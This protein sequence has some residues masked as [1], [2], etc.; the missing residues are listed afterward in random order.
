MED[1][2]IAA[3]YVRVSTDDQIE[4]SP[5][6]QL[7]VIRDHAQREGYIVPEDLIF[8]DDAI[9]GKHAEKRPQFMLLIAKA[10]EPDPGFDRIYVWEFSRF[11]RN[12]EESIVYKNLLRKR[13]ITV[14]SIKEPLADSPF[15]SLIERIIEWM[16]EYYLINLATEVKRGLN[17]KASR[18]EPIGSAPFG[19]S[20]SHSLKAYT[21]NETEAETVRLIFHQYAA[22]RSLSGLTHDLNENGFRTRAGNTFD[23]R[24]VK[25]ILSNPA[26]IGNLRWSPDGHSNYSRTGED[27]SRLKIFEGKHEPII[28]QETFQAVQKRISENA[29]PKGTYKR[30]EDYMLRGLIKC[31][32][33]GATLSRTHHNPKKGTPGLQCSKYAAGKCLVSHA[34]T[35]PS[36]EAAI[37]SYLENAVSSGEY[38]FQ[39]PPPEDKIAANKS[40]TKLIESENRR[41]ERARSAFLDGTFSADEYRSAKESAE[42]NITKLNKAKD[43][44]EKEIQDRKTTPPSTM[45]RRIRNVLTLLKDP[46][47]PATAKNE[48]LH[49]VIDHIVFNRPEQRFEIYFRP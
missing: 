35:I 39:P 42:A 12:Q 4:Y 36:A 18:G 48:A 17:E 27:L 30:G 31:S 5:D 44:A 25:Y 16:D 3:A 40:I 43:K 6:S 8:Q 46:E 20:Y 23:R 34:V 2:K 33:C 26:Y 10:K 32:S 13:G 22:G 28:D 37:I 19:Y 21:I 9:S 7:R 11:A 41:I 24:A 14:Q 45:K 1:I 15:A 38:Y 29:E 47:I 49:M